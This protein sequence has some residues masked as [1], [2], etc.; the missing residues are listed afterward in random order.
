MVLSSFPRH[1]GAALQAGVLP[2][3]RACSPPDDWTTCAQVACIV[4]AA[5]TPAAFSAVFS[6]ENAEVTLAVVISG[7]VSVVVSVA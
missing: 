7:V 1:W 5:A 6:A 4:V 3:A 2:S